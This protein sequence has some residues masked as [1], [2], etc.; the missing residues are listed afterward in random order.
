M[1]RFEGWLGIGALG[2]AG[3]AT[4]LGLIAFSPEGEKAPD[5]PLDIIFSEQTAPRRF[6]AAWGGDASLAWADLTCRN[7]GGT[8]KWHGGVW[9]RCTA[10]GGTP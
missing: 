2:A 8:P 4:C 9:M 7:L 3:V 6:Q 10:E 1:S 5:A